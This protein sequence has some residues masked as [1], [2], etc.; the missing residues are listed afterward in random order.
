MAK[1]KFLKSILDNYKAAEDFYAPEYERGD[2]DGRFA[3]GEQWPEQARQM[4]KN[5]P[6]L[7]ENRTLSF[8]NQVVNSIRQARPSAVVQPV[9]DKGD[10][11]IAEIL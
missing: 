10:V 6:M 11:R 7:T 4:R 5:R 3:L 1:D 9:D 2:E 8:V